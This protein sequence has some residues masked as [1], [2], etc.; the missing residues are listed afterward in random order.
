VQRLRFPALHSLHLPSNA[1]LAAAMTAIFFLT[2]FGERM[3]AYGRP[4]L[5]ACIAI[6]MAWAAISRAGRSHP[7]PWLT[8]IA[9]MVIHIATRWYE[10][11]NHVYLALYWAIAI[12]AS[13]FFSSP[14]SREAVLDRGA[15][16]LIASTMLIAA[17]QKL[18]SDDYMDGR[19][20][21]VQMLT[22]Q[23]FST[24]ASLL[25]L[26]LDDLVAQNAPR[27]ADAHWEFGESRMV[28]LEVGNE[29]L[30]SRLLAVC[31]AASQATAVGELALGALFAAPRRWGF[32]AA[33]HLALLGFML[34]TYSL[35]PVR[36]FGAVLGLLGLASS[37][38][39]LVLPYCLVILY[40]YYAADA[41]RQTVVD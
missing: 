8:V 31:R 36:G 32:G 15:R 27:L 22:Q 19:M 28:P 24:L 20:M 4:I 10:T 23:R 35:L 37:P 21:F 5:S 29:A 34:L 13:C 14:R 3:I 9:S 12:G 17:V 18:L 16:Y 11:D 30:R 41:F 39:K 38:R 25:Q 1:N 40:V 2:Y 33:A 26:P 7:L 6:A